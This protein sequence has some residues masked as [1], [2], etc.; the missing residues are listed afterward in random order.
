MYIR[1]LLALLI[2][3]QLSACGFHLRGSNQIA[4]RFNPL[5]VEGGQLEASQLALIRKELNNSSAKLSAIID[6][7]NRLRVSINPVKSRKIAISSVTDVE[8]VQLSISLRFSVLS[9]SGNYLLE[10]RELVQNADVELDNA[11]V[12]GH[13]Q[14]IKRVSI[15]LQRRLIRSMISQLSR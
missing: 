5:F 4:P 15:D 6:G 3:L 1:L 11:N 10:Q 8:L 9:E 2:L 12:L 13:E 14:I 7:S